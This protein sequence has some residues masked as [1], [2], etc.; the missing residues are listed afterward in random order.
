MSFDA[1]PDPANTNPISKDYYVEVRKGNISGSRIIEVNGVSLVAGTEVSNVWAVGGLLVYP[2]AGEQWEL[3]FAEANDTAAGT[4]AQEVTV[5]YLDDTYVEQS[6]VVASNGGTVVMSATDAFRFIEA[7]VTAVGSG[8]KNEGSITVQVTSGGAARA[9]MIA[10]KNVTLS[11]F[12]TVP[13]GKTAS[14]IYAYTGV[15][16]NKDSQMA[17]F[18]T[19]GDDGIFVETLPLIVYQNTFDLS[20]PAPAVPMQAKTDLQVQVIS[21]NNSTK[22]ALFSQI[23]EVDDA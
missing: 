6:E 18:M 8:A 20:P 11:G 14:I 16:K 23:L 21:E 4:G 19:D 22:V 7:K 13:L 3:V 5:R 15:Q 12:Y 1:F 9:L 10:E 2:T 17:I